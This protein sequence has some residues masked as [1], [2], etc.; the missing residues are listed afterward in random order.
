MPGGG[1]GFDRDH[2]HNSTVD[3]KWTVQPRHRETPEPFVLLS[4]DKKAT[5]LTVLPKRGAD[6]PGDGDRLRAVLDR[7]PTRV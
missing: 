2:G 1:L 3:I 6:H 5:G 4:G 7:N